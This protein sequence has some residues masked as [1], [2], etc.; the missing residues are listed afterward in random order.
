MDI[1]SRSKGIGS[2][3]NFKIINNTISPKNKSEK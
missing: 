3:L 1:Y 2:N